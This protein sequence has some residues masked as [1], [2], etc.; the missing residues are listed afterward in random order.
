MTGAPARILVVDDDENNRT[1]MQ[2]L[3]RS[4]GHETETCE[5]ADAAFAAM[6]ARRP[7]LVLLDIGLPRVDGFGVLRKMKGDAALAEI[8]VIIVTAMADMDSKVKGIELGAE[9]Y[10]TKPFKLFELQTRVRAALQVRHYQD[11]LQSAERALAEQ[12]RADPVT[13][14]GQFAQLHAHL[15]YE[16]TRARRYG[17]PLSGLLVAVDDF[18]AL[19]SKVGGPEGDRLLHAVA[20]VLGAVTR[21]VDRLFRL[22]VE[23]FVV[24]LPE[25]PLAGA[26]V[27]A[28]RVRERLK[29][30]DLGLTC[31]IGVAAFPH[32][33]IR[34]GED[35]LKAADAALRTARGAGP[36]HVAQFGVDG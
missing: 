27:V 8:P 35:L 16:V 3:C 17:R 25:T 30:A 29:E 14:A 1:L 6:A 28:E 12:G 9:D 31:S 2:E 34:G 11:R 21:H 20:E 33:E 32:A 15:D 7:D 26:V 18:I 24:L 36:D 22:D 4:L 10:L 13:G 5:D 19:R 23:E